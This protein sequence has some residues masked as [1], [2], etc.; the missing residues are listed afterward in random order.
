MLLDIKV[1]SNYVESSDK[2]LELYTMMQYCIAILKEIS[3]LDCSTSLVTGLTYV[4][5]RIFLGHD[6]SER[7]LPLFV[8]L[9]VSLQIWKP[10]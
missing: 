1:Y 7:L 9:G 6:F 4:C 5:C 2:I 8:M 10:R 3:V